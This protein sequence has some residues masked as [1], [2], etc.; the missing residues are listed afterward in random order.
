MGVILDGAKAMLIDCGEGSVAAVL[1]S[2]GVASVDAI[3]FTHHHRDH[4]CGVRGFGSGVRIGTPASERRYFEDTDSYWKDPKNRWH[5]YNQHPHHLMLAESVRVDAV[6]SDG[7]KFAWG[8]AKLTALG[9]PGHT[10][11][12]LSF[13]VEVD[14]KRIVFC[15]D[16]IYD[17]GRL[18]ELWSLQKGTTTSDY[19][20]FLGARQQLAQSLRRIKAVQPDLL[21]PTHGRVM[22][23]PSQAIDRLLQRLDAVYERYAAIS[24]LR[25]Y[26]PNMFAENSGSSGRM[27][28]RPGKAVPDCLRHI[29]TTWMLVS[30]DKSAFVMDCGSRSVVK[31]IQVMLERGDLRRVEGLWITHYHDDHVDAVPVFQ[32]AFPDSP[33]I[34]DGS[35]AEV[36]TRPA[37]WRLP[38][39]SPARARVDRRTKDGESWQWREFQF[40]AYHFPGQTHYHA[41]L[42]VEGR[43]LRMFFTGDSFTPAGI[44]DYC[45]YNRN[46]LG[47]H[48]GFD[49]CIALL[50][51][52][53]PTHL[54]NCH[55]DRS[56][57][58]TDE[59]Y[60]FMRANLAE[61]E[62]LLGELVPWDHANYGTD[63]PWVRCDPYE[64]RA[65][66]GKSATI[67]VVITN[68]SSEPRTAS[69]RLVLPQ[70]WGGPRNASAWPATSERDFPAS[71]PT[72]NLPA[73]SEGRIRLSVPVP[74]DLKPGRYILPID[75]RYD[76]W[77][78]PQHT[79]AIVEW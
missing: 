57:D 9:T 25:H 61:R 66:P 49:R 23:N 45:T 13:L 31:A 33:C 7:Q 39:I 32:E 51:E 69:C 78:L 44:D 37:A 52:L 68:H 50:Q 3:W 36:I 20:A 22:A 12:S 58:F 70:A 34:T 5:L 75:V 27:P 43:G 56:F 67:D 14:G 47:R 40:T 11:G 64:Q 35:V 19:H 46:W 28:I 4:A 54:F 79:E 42:L 63:E 38:C 62:T 17:E 73:K 8:P 15:G 29:G 59:Q 2:L 21:V 48:V 71:W 26:F 72:A 74:A 1:P 53:R 60:R 10:D 16:A 6:A 18:W 41:G 30:E 65:V 24:A 55:V 76:R 77:A